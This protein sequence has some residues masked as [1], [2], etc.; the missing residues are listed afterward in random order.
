MKPITR[1]DVE[2]A[3]AITRAHGEPFNREGWDRIVTRHNGHL[4]LEIRALP[5]GMVVPAGVPLIQVENTDPTTPWLTTFIETAILRGIWY[6]S[7]VATLSGLAKRKILAGLQKTSDDPAGQIGIAFQQ[8]V[9]DLS[10][11]Y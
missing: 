10:Q 8:G 1:E 6:P 3:D 4:P 2:E 7:T 11:Q 9:A 5:E